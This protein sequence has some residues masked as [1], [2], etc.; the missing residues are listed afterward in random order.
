[1]PKIVSPQ[2]AKE[3]TNMYLPFLLKAEFNLA[4]MNLGCGSG[5]QAAGIRSL[6][7]ML[8]ESQL[9]ESQ[10]TKLKELIKE[11]TYITPNNKQSKL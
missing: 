10:L 9:S 5:L 6:M 3:K 1:M 4:L 8:T 7:R 2:N 11:E